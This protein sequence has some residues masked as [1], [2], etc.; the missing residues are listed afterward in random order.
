M[1]ETTIALAL[2][3]L[4]AAAPALAQQKKDDARRQLNQANQSGRTFDGNRSG[5]GNSTLNTRDAVVA[6]PAAAPKRTPQQAAQEYRNSGR[7]DPT[8]KSFRRQS[9]PPPAPGGEAPKKKP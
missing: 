6:K 9:P 2:A 8:P 4:L 3:A 5:S 1:R 7:A